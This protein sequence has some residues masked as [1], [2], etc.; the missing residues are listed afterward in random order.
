MN[1]IAREIPERQEPTYLLSG[2]Q[3]NH[4]FTDRQLIPVKYKGDP[5]SN[6][7]NC[8]EIIERFG[9]EVKT[10]MF[11]KPESRYKFF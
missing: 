10:T 5:P 7:I 1:P 3:P 8:D 9:R 4:S 11:T 6:L 2:I